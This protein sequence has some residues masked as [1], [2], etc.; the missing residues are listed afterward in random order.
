MDVKGLTD[1]ELRYVYNGLSSLNYA[2]YDTNERS[3]IHSLRK[4][5]MQELKLRKAWGL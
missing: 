3:E 5:L 2:R 4:E 1:N